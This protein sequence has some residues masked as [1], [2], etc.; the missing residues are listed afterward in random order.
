[1]KELRNKIFGI[2]ESMVFITWIFS[3]LKKRENR[4]NNMFVDFSNVYYY[5]LAN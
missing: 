1:M 2:L 5:I 3:K 4:M